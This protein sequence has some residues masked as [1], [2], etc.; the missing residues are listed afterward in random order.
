MSQKLYVN[1][2]EWIKDT[3]QFNRDF[4]KN[5]NIES[6]ERYFSEVDSQYFEKIND[7]HNDLA[8][9]PE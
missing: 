5:Y 3:S 7:L 6:Y 4:I 9:L 1:N 2:F 8:F